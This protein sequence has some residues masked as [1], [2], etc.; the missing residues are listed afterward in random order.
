MAEPKNLDNLERVLE[1]LLFAY[2][3]C[4]SVGKLA[5]IAK[6]PAAEV[7]AALVRLKANLASRG[8]NMVNKDDVWQLT[9]AKE[10]SPFIEKLVKSEMQ[11]ELT[12]AGLEVLAI[13]AYRGPVSKGEIEAIRG[14]NCAYALRNLTLRGLIEKNE[15]V[16][17]Q[18]HN[19]SLAALRKL[20]LKNAAE[21]PGY[22]EHRQ[23]LNR[24]TETISAD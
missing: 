3:E 9:A 23:E 22:H 11:E 7:V 8:I 10:C 1:G 15:K 21:L 5:N 24:I 18:T 19:I 20:G 12:P 17:P 16:K 2:G 6:K 14:V 13:A 4:L